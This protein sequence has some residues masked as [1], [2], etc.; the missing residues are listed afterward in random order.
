MRKLILLVMAMPIIAKAQTS[1]V[2]S[3]RAD[4]NKTEYVQAKKKL[5]EARRS[6]SHKGL[7]I[8][9]GYGFSRMMYLHQV[10]EIG[11]YNWAP[12]YN[13]T[14]EYKLKRLSFGVNYSHISEL[15]FNSDSRSGFEPITYVGKP[16]YN[17]GA[18]V[19]FHTYTGIYFGITSSLAR[20]GRV[21]YYTKEIMEYYTGFAGGVQ[22]GYSHSIYRGLCMNAQ[23][24]MTFMENYMSYYQAIAGLRYRF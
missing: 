17:F 16:V 21:N 12:A 4:V 22:V 18:Q 24:G 23:F 19:N 6:S 20:L 9:V 5:R 15:S 3:A 7:E 1:S 10:F 11:S 14:A 2:E 13:V 8:G